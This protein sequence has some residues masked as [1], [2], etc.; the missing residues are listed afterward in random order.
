MHRFVKEL[1]ENYKCNRLDEKEVVYSLENHLRYESE[2]Y[3]NLED[4]EIKIDD[5]E[6]DLENRDLLEQEVADLEEELNNKEEEIAV[7]EQQIEELE[8]EIKITLL[9]TGIGKSKIEVK[10]PLSI[11]DEG[12]LPLENIDI[13]PSFRNTK[14]K[15]EIWKLEFA[16]KF[17]TVGN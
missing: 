14:K 2:Q 13:P 16:V 10:K 9:A 6:E 11:R 17:S 1:L 15:G 4:L 12:A 3:D 8:N 7:L 5:L